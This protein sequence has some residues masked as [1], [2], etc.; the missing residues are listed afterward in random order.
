M[1]YMKKAMAVIMVFVI[2]SAFA[3][4]GKKEETAATPAPSE[5]SPSLTEKTTTQ[6]PEDNPTKTPTAVSASTEEPA[7]E[8]PETAATASPEPETSSDST[9]KPS[10][11]STPQPEKESGAAADEL[12]GKAEGNK[13][14]NRYFGFTL[15]VPE[16]WY[17]T[18]GEKLNRIMEPAFEYVSDTTE[19]AINEQQVQQILPLALVTPSDPE[20]GSDAQIACLAQNISKFSKMVK[21]IRSY[22]N[23]HVQAIKSK[24]SDMTFGDIE[25]LNIDGHEVARVSAVQ[26]VEGTPLYNTVIYAFKEDEYV[27]I[28]TSVSGNEEEKK[29]LEEIMGTLSFK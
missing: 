2:I 1:K 4:C 15:T 3:G 19:G 14:V 13:Y 7:G 11:T 21:D 10:A 29:Q 24:N 17:I 9:P 20:Q 27:V 22:M 28:F 16:G 26:T 23:I 6:E 12:N 18:S 5:S 8:T 25:V